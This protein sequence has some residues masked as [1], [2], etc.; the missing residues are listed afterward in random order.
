M[1]KAKVHSPL[2]VDITMI[3]IIL[4]DAATSARARSMSPV[5]SDGGLPG[6]AENRPIH[7]IIQ[8]WMQNRVDSNGVAPEVPPRVPSP[9][10]NDTF[11]QALTYHGDWLV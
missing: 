4:A 9:A 3:L 7:Q 5:F 11:E 6:L 8:E 2:H 10:G 1:G